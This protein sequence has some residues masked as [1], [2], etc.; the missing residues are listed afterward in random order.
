MKAKR[1]ELTPSGAVISPI[2]LYQLP[3][4]REEN[5]A[6]LLKKYCKTEWILSS[7]PRSLIQELVF[8]FSGGRHR[9]GFL[10]RV[11][12]QTGF[13]LLLLYFIYFIH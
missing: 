10:S 6:Y 5:T 1:A 8:Y 4:H 11:T 2:V 3:C 13:F 12:H 9:W 7:F